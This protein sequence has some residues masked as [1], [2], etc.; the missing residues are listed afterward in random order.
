VREKKRESGATGHA[1]LLPAPSPAPEEM[2]L[3]AGEGHC[4][5]PDP[6]GGRTGPEDEH[7]S[8]V[9]ETDTHPSC[10]GDEVHDPASPPPQT[11]QAPLLLPPGKTHGR[12]TH[13]K[14]VRTTPP[15]DK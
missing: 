2:D 9:G 3:A 10:R 13:V 4:G 11:I 6:S 1:E 5:E 12:M 7:R 8:S 14:T 15:F